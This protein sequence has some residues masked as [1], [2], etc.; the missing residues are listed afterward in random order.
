[1]ILSISRRSRSRSISDLGQKMEKMLDKQDQMLDRQDETT[2]EVRGLRSD[3]KESLDVRLRRIEAG[4]RRECCRPWGRRAAS[5]RFN[6]PPHLRLRPK[7]RRAPPAPWTDPAVD[8]PR[9]GRI[10]PGG[11][12]GVLGAPGAVGAHRPPRPR[13]PPPPDGGGTA[14]RVKSAL[15]EKGILGGREHRLF[16]DSISTGGL[17]F[18]PFDL[19]TAEPIAGH[20]SSAKRGP[21]P[22]GKP[23]RRPGG[24]RAPRSGQCTFAPGSG[25]YTLTLGSKRI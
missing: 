24:P 16:S 3:L 18:A 20:R 19:G 4:P 2:G 7:D 25:P 9:P 8:G 23:V 10:P 1:M 22:S 13:R 12:R 6:A 21:P 17:C 14:A 5:D 11:G 15:G